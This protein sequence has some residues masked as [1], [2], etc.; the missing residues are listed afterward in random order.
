L[1][2]QSIQSNASSYIFSKEFQIIYCLS[3]PTIF[4]I[5]PFIP[6]SLEHTYALSDLQYTKIWYNFSSLILDVRF[7]IFQETHERLQVITCLLDVLFSES[8]FLPT[9]KSMHANNLHS[10]CIWLGHDMFSFVLL[11]IIHAYRWIIKF[12]KYL[13]LYSILMQFLVYFFCNSL[14]TSRHVYNLIAYSRSSF[15]LAYVSHCLCTKSSMYFLF[16]LD[17]IKCLYMG[18]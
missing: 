12:L 3:V 2:S 17:Y 6:I 16:W 14:L 5:S 1:N 15:Y 13:V 18:Y 7:D 9:L 11:Y 8:I 4:V 10:W